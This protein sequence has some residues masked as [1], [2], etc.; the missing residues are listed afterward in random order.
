MNG[1]FSL[2]N[3]ES[4]YKKGDNLPGKPALKLNFSSKFKK[5]S[6]GLKFN[7][8]TSRHR[9]KTLVQSFSNLLGLRFLFAV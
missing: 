8:P 4:E 5:L 9:A 3:T 6:F 1:V 2:E 7:S